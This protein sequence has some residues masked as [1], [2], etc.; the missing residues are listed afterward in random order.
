MPESRRVAWASELNL[1]GG[2]G[3][4]VVNGESAAFAGRGRSAGA[5]LGRR[6][7]NRVEA[8]VVEAAGTPGTWRFELDT[9]GSLQPGTIRVIAGEI[10]LVT[11]S[12]VVF[13]LKGRPGER[14]VFSFRTDR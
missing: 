11:E 7:V 6:G 10:A 3:Q 4:V 8:Q 14:V 5:A 1:E 13:R 9:T 12:A 2:S